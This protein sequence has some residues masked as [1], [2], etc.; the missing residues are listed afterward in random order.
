M[1]NC[2]NNNDQLKQKIPITCAQ[3][4]LDMGSTILQTACLMKKSVLLNPTFTPDVA[5][6]PG[7]LEITC[8]VNDQKVTCNCKDNV[9]SNAL[10]IKHNITETDFT[11]TNSHHKSENEIKPIKN[12]GQNNYK[13]M[14]DGIDMPVDNSKQETNTKIMEP[15]APL[16]AQNTENVVMDIL[17][18]TD[19]AM[20]TDDN[21]TEAY[22]SDCSNN[23]PELAVIAH[24]ENSTT[25]VNL[26]L[27]NKISII[28]EQILSS[29]QFKELK[30][31]HHRN[32]DIS[33][34][35]PIPIN[36]LVTT[37]K[38][39]D[40]NCNQNIEACF[41]ANANEPQQIL[42]SISKKIDSTLQN[43]FQNSE[44][45]LMYDDKGVRINPENCNGNVH[46][47]FPVHIVGNESLTLDE[48][49]TVAEEI[50]GNVENPAELNAD[51]NFD[52][53]MD[54]NVS[55]IEKHLED[56]EEIL[57]NFVN[58]ITS[59]DAIIE[60]LDNTE[61]VC[62]KK[63]R[64]VTIVT[65]TEFESNHV[66]NI[67]QLKKPY[68]NQSNKY[69]IDV[70]KPASSG[71]D[72]SCKNNN[73]SAASYDPSQVTE[74]AKTIHGSDFVYQ[75]LPQDDAFIKAIDAPQRVKDSISKESE[76]KSSINCSAIQNSKNNVKRKRSYALSNTVI[77]ETKKRFTCDINTADKSKYYDQSKNIVEKETGASEKNNKKGTNLNGKEHN[78]K[79]G[80]N[81][82]NNKLYTSDEVEEIAMLLRQI[83]RRRSES[84]KPLRQSIDHKWFNAKCQETYKPRSKMHIQGVEKPGGSVS[85]DDNINMNKISIK[86]YKKS[87]KPKQT[88]A[89]TT[90]RILIQDIV[91]ND[92]SSTV[93]SSKYDQERISVDFCLCKDFGSLTCYDDERLYEHI[94]FLD[95]KKVNCDSQFL[96]SIY[97]EEEIAKNEKNYDEEIEQESRPTSTFSICW[98]NLVNNDVTEVK[99]LDHIDKTFNEINSISDFST[100][101]NTEI[102]QNVTDKMIIKSSDSSN[103]SSV[104]ID[105]SV[106]NEIKLSKRSPILIPSCEPGSNINIQMIQSEAKTVLNQIDNLREVAIKNNMV[107]TE[108]QNNPTPKNF[109]IC[110]L[111]ENVEINHASCSKGENEENSLRPVKVRK[112]TEIKS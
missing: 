13:N 18:I 15:V 70:V 103:N 49:Y 56:N 110:Q 87:N 83:T 17:E 71:D 9:D 4:G 66:T 47:N 107:D 40:D 84:V 38:L 36:S 86:T 100:N 53:C 67:F 45:V 94:H 108:A 74:R 72:Y 95:H 52:V 109:E 43:S 97:N 65:D 10:N 98:N 80:I 46:V 30:Y 93:E 79:D 11:V 3:N 37:N 78:A 96:F 112:S 91:N 88:P 23:N 101:L 8:A 105:A 104:E 16:Q 75:N 34:F 89:F 111:P 29:S 61:E 20:P 64:E 24:P 68:N 14:E 26:E 39:T 102:D 7:E 27:N 1:P 63:P 58:E 82:T 48:K 99:N 31:L 5:N 69:E 28:S 2:S 6:M 76:D 73:S 55:D 44:T 77:I 81:S 25:Q 35:L 42:Q 106:R 19:E 90:K 57:E 21:P 92:L 54:F 41:P 12:F 85:V 62:S 33:N 59:C 22:S 51:S 60:N 50:L 32:P